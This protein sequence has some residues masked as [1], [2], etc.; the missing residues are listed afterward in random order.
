[1]RGPV[2]GWLL[3]VSVYLL[4][5]LHRTSLGVAGLLAERRFGITP[6]QLSVFIFLQLGVYAAMQVPTG[7]LV[8]RYGPRRILL[9]AAGLMGCAQL[10]FA[11]VP[12]YAAGLAARAVLGCGDALTFVSVLRFAA[13]HF[14]PRRFPLIVAVTGMVGMV[15]NV[16]AT[17]P[18]AIVL[19][20][21]GWTVGFAAAGTL[22]L[23]GAI[24]VAALLRD[25]T[26]S[27]RPLRGMGDVRRGV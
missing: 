26:P 24:A 9:V 14:A 19:R 22:S 8:D 17:L 12:S 1:M 4:A 23:V 18:L 2:A 11:L 5:V 20:R 10:V 6:A 16:L 13:T 25:P 7:V 21:A 27:P 15:G 3:A